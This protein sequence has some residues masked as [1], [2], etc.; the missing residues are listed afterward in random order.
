MCK[1]CPS[2]NYSE[3]L[4]SAG[5]FIAFVFVVF[6]LVV[7]AVWRLE[8]ATNYSRSSP[9]AHEDGKVWACAFVSSKE[10][11]MWTVSS[12]QILAIAATSE[13]SGEPAFITKIFEFVSFFNL[14]TR[15][16]P[17]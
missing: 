8:I 3:L 10:F 2:E 15:H 13:A 14:D 7:V 11:C 9:V 17:S 12:A 4:K 1:P 6:M 16:T 5:P